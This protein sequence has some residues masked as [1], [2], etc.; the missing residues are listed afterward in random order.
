MARGRAATGHAPGPWDRT[1]QIAGGCGRGR[2]GAGD[3]AGNEDP[4][5]FIQGIRA[6]G[7]CKRFPRARRNFR[8]PRI[9]PPGPRR[10]APSAARPTAF[11]EVSLAALGATLRGWQTIPDP[12]RWLLP[13]GRARIGAGSAPQP[14]RPG[15]KLR[16]ESSRHEPAESSLIPEDIPGV[17]RR[18]HDR[19][20]QV[21]RPGPRGQRRHPARRRR[22][23]R[24]RRLAMSTSSRKMDGVEIT[25]LI[26]PDSRTYN[27]R[28]T[29]RSRSSRAGPTPRRRSRTSAEALDD[30]EPRRHLDRHAQ[31]LARPDDHL[32]LPGRQGRLRREAV[33]PQRPRGAGRRR[34]R[35]EVRPDRPARHA[36]PHRRRQW[37]DVARAGQVGPVRQAPGLPRAL[38]QA[39]VR[40]AQ[41][42]HRLQVRR[43]A[44]PSGT[45]LQ[46][47]DGPGA[48]ARLQPQLSSTTT[49]TGSG[50]TATA[51]SATRG[52]TRWTSPA[53]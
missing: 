20:D 53:G 46:P 28:T 22:P 9:P 4:F 11:A 37:A 34:G 49:G 32:G 29:A 35:P 25:Y 5:S 23:Q 36:E 50:T 52:S 1:K 24:A 8:P 12:C 47:L 31:P 39:P 30:K 7:T 10:V 13:G 27:K 17:R 2:G 45:R 14:A 51:T 16:G 18:V 43:L 21:V 15:R 26:D 42:Q 40:K 38:L 44:A 3:L 33:Q 41:R 19:R 48:G 6:S